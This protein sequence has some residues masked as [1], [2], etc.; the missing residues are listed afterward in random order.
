MNEKIQKING[1][2]MPLS[3]NDIDTDRIIPARYLICVTFEGLGESVFMDDRLGLKGEHPFDKAQH[4]GAKILLAGRNFGC[5]SSREHAPQALKRWGIQA[6]AAVSFSE[7]F[8]GNCVAL[9]MPCVNISDADVDFCQSYIKEN[10]NSEVMV[11]LVAKKVCVGGK[12]IGLA[13][14]EGAR[15][16][17]VSGS[18]DAMGELMAAQSL[19][20][21][22]YQRLPYTQSYSS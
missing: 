6:I 13:I 14:D 4:Q 18:W 21:S 5:G 7:I 11:D 17:F 22:C 9:G 1:K 10:P 19:T 8:F 3:G 2:G 16:Q 12:T 15:Q 20:E